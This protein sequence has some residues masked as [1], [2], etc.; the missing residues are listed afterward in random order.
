IISGIYK[1]LCQLQYY[2]SFVLGLQIYNPFFRNSKRNLH[3]F[4]TN[5]LTHC[6]IAKYFLKNHKLKP[7]SGRIPAKTSAKSIE[8]KTKKCLAICDYSTKREEKFGLLNRGSI[9][10]LT[11]KG[12]LHRSP[13][14]VE[15]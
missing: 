2:S 15:Y 10:L 11:I 5:T 12:E 3:L 9:V 7:K 1:L 8:G 6:Y 4:Y 13:F 14:L